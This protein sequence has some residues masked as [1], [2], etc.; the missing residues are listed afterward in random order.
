MKEAA[1]TKKFY[2]KLYE[3]K[4]IEILELNHLNEETN[5]KFSK[6]NSI[7][8]KLYTK[9]KEMNAQVNHLR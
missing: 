3:K 4:D 5:N 2:E 6:E 1:E 8:D 7:V 9:E